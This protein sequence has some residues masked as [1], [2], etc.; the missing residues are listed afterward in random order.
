MHNIVVAHWLRKLIIIS[1]FLILPLSD[2]LAVPVIPGATGF[3]MDT[4]AGRGGKVY[5]VTNLNEAG[6]GSLAE[7]ATASGPRVC[8]FEV[9]GTI[10]LDRD[11]RIRDPYITIAGQTA[12]SPGITI[13]GAALRVETSH[14]LIQHVRLRPGGDE[15]GHPPLTRDGLKIFAANTDDFVTNVV[16]DHV[17]VSWSTNVLAETRMN[18][19]DV[20][21]RN[22]IFSEP[23]HDS[24]HPKGPHGYGPLFI[25][26]D[27]ARVSVINN[28][29]AHG[30]ER[31]PR[32]ATNLYF[33]NN[34]VYN[35]RDRG[36]EIFNRYGRPSKTSLIGNVY[37][38]G[39]D[40]GS[41]RGIV[42]QPNRGNEDLWMVKG[43]QV[44]LEDNR[45]PGYSASDPW[46]MVINNADDWVKASS[47]PIAVPGFR[48]MPAT[49]VEKHVL[50]NA[51]ARPVDRDSVDERVIRDIA[52]G[53]GRIVDSQNDV[54][55]WPNLPVNRRPLTLPSNPN[56]D[57]NGNGYTN[58]EEWLHAF[59]ASVEGA[60]TAPRPPT[61]LTVQ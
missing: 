5:K 11:L 29:I 37:K 4:P 12:P 19:G 44:Y 16:I 36:T 41:T 22:S 14:V 28:I 40:T 50:V 51:G 13:R 1:A 35:W 56:S 7:C 55:G 38:P 58:L 46:S 33:A 18:V 61:G 15:D 32:T 6:S 52:N 8:V 20:T 57:S 53:Q 25:G 43:S 9:S 27:K 17:S 2:A 42:I 24:V 54:G 48:P 49:E 10:R 3:G 34:L 59:A 21:I 26:Y 31:N 45:G 23:M 47:P 39:R 30:V 60:A